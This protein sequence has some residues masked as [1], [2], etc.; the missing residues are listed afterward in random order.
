MTLPARAF[1]SIEVMKL[2]RVS[3]QETGLTEYQHR[4]ELQ[5]ETFVFFIEDQEE[6]EAFH[7]PMFITSE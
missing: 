3:V 2:P 1:K 6:Y 5:R 4:P 7:I